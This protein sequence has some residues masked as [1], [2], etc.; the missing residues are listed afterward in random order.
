MGDEKCLAHRFPN[1]NYETCKT[2]TGKGLRPL[3]PK[4]SYYYVTIFSSLLRS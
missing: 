2:S 3:D 1:F 4:C